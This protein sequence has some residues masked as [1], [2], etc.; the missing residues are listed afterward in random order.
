VAYVPGFQYDLF[1]SYAASKDDSRLSQ[2]VDDLREYL[3][4]ELGKTLFTRESVFFAPQD[5]KRTPT[6]WKKNLQHS[7]ES[8]AILLPFLSQSY[9]GSPY[10]A[11]EWEWFCEEHPLRWKAGTEEVFRVC[12]VQWRSLDEEM[13]QQ[14]APEI[15]DA[16]WSLMDAQQPLSVEELGSKI[17]SGLR[18]MRRSRHTV[19]VGECEN[20]VRQKVLDEMNRMGFRVMPVAPMAYG[21][22]PQI[23]KHLG[24][25]RLAVH[26]VGGQTQQRALDAIKWS[27]Q[28]SQ[29]ATVVYE[30]PGYDLTPEER[31]SLEW[32]EEDL[33]KA[34]AGDP[35]AYDQVSRKNVDQFLQIL[36]DRLESVRPVRPTPLGI[37]CEE[38]DRPAV[39]AIIP[40]IHARTGFSV[41]CHGLSLLDFKK[42]RG[43]LFYWGA[44]EGR[45]LR[46]ARVVTKGLL[47]AFF[48]GPPPKPPGHEQELGAALVFRQKG[49]RF[50]VEDIRPFLLKLGWV[51]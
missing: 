46:Q 49:D 8:A 25:A 10:C 41:I 32:S 39:E 3:A 19:Y 37:A 29:G 9:A 31:Y 5:L 21:D 4:E 15:R 14:L 45:R 11:K 44:A 34:T 28:D 33:R 47:E 6:E 2:F 36:R 22:P 40:E 42:S 23:R 43:V 7:A 30:V 12:P 48:L 1:V 18:L 13:L 16:Q 20:G 38:T 50:Q 24:E 17:A 51:G 27:R 26:F 35:R